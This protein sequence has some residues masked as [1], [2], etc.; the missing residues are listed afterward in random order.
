MDFGGGLLVSKLFCSSV[1][2]LC[3][4][5]TL[6]CSSDHREQNIFLFS[7]LYFLPDFQLWMFLWTTALI[8]LNR[9]V[10]RSVVF[11]PLWH[12]DDNRNRY[13]PPWK[14]S[15]LCP[16]LRVAVCLPVPIFM[17]IWTTAKVEWDC[18]L[19]ILGDSSRLREV[20]ERSCSYS[21]TS[22]ILSVGLCRRLQQ[23]FCVRL[24]EAK[25]YF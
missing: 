16:T 17:P 12:H 11:M 3:K 2:S 15:A 21:R 9:E 5:L 23:G 8:A 22:K 13:L 1:T 19:V 18:F 24:L 7:N 6:H 10:F 20:S 4:S 14:N 25:N